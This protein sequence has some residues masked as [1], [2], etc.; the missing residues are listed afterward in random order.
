MTNS[1]SCLPQPVK[2][3]CNYSTQFRQFPGNVYTCLCSADEALGAVDLK[4]NVTK[5]SRDILWGKTKKSFQYVWNH[6]REDADWFMKADDDT[7]VVLENLKAMLKDVDPKQAVYY[8]A[9]FDIPG[10]KD[11]YMSGGSGY[12]L[13]KE[14]LRR[15]IQEGLPDPSKCEPRDEFEDAVEDTEMGT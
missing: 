14:A 12:V 10:F 3:Q 13:S 5:E 8:G 15:F 11:G 6:H 9:R 2:I 7:Y 4:L 1:Y